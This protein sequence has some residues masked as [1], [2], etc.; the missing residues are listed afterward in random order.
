MC[1]KD[2]ETTGTVYAGGL[3]HYGT[4]SLIRFSYESMYSYHTTVRV[5]FAC[6]RIPEFIMQPLIPAQKDCLITFLCGLMPSVSDPDVQATG[7]AFRP[8]KRTSGTSKHEI[9]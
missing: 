1:V 9:Y 7:E 6:Y 8:Q 5:Q 4:G 2:V 3:K